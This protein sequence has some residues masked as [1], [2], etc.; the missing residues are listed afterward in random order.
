MIAEESEY[1]K[2]TPVSLYIYV[3]DVDAVFRKAVS[4]GGEVSMEPSDM[5]YGD[6][7]GAIEDSAGN[8]WNIATHKEDIEP[9]KLRSALRNS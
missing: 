8:S 4:A 2:A 1:A 3:P 6:R 7:S 5:F 9:A